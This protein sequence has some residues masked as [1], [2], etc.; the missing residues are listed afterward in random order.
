MGRK[1]AAISCGGLSDETELRGHNRTWSGAQPGRVVRQLVE[2]GV[3]N[4]VCGW[5]ADR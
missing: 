3:K 2:I 1:L 4:P 5:D